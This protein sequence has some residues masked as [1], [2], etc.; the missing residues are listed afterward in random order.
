MQPIATLN[1][2][3]SKSMPHSGTKK[4]RDTTAK[5]KG[6]IMDA[7]AILEGDLFICKDLTCAHS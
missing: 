3:Q 5:N 4:R 2:M 1:P 7:L 6:E